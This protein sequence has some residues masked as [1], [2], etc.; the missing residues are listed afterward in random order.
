MPSLPPAFSLKG[1]HVRLD[2]GR[3]CLSLSSNLHGTWSEANARK[4]EEAIEYDSTRFETP[5]ETRSCYPDASRTY[6]T[7]SGS[8]A[9]ETIYSRFHDRNEATRLYQESTQHIFHADRTRAVCLVRSC[10]AGDRK[11]PWAELHKSPRGMSQCLCTMW[12][13]LRRKGNAVVFVWEAWADER[14]MPGVL[15][16]GKATNTS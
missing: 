7:Q 12:K 1:Q 14:P 11:R 9:S 8:C 13:R 2:M 3:S 10:L 15:G 16:R 4:A 6:P 5:G